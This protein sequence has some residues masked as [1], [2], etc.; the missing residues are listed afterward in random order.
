[1]NA[2]EKRNN[3][4]GTVC[5][6]LATLCWG[7]SGCSGQYLLHDLSL[8]TPVVLCIRQVSAG[9]ILIVLDK[10]FR[11]KGKDTQPRPSI[12]KSKQDC[13]TLLFFSLFGICLTQFS[14]FMAIYYADSGTAT[15]LQYLSTII[16]LIVTCIQQRI[17]PKREELLAI[18]AAV[19]GTFVISTGGRFNQLAISGHALF[20]G[21]VCAL[22]YSTY[23]LVPGQIVRTY[24]S[25]YIVGRGMLISGIFLSI[26]VRPWTYHL[27]LSGQV[28]LGFCGL[29][30]IGTAAGSTLYHFGASLL[31]PVK[32]G[33]IAN[34][35][36]V[37]SVILTAV[38]LGT[39]FTA[40]DLVGFV[41]II[42]AVFLL[43]LYWIKKPSP[44]RE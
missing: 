15:V 9:L 35:D 23:T 26:F 32:A 5:I 14:F 8:P 43:N 4:V 39:K 28:L 1:M 29:I 2:L 41:L 7:L 31:P 19:A 21:I 13:K 24:G 36:P 3:V 37:S 42:S 38:L 30:L 40:A 44:K 11:Q 12:W 22:A 25:K 27:E 20:F 10:L 18:L 16:I 6:I 34:F 33:I 17:F